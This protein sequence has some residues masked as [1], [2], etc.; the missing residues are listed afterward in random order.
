MKAVAQV[1]FWRFEPASLVLALYDSEGRYFYEVDLE[2]CRTSAEVLDW[3][4]QVAGKTW[5][6]DS[7][8]AGLVRGLDE[9]LD[10][11]GRLCSGGMERGPLNIPLLLKGRP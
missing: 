8:V 2:R 7:I 1:G 4:A 3:I 9:L 10:L 6:T 11:Q 5:C